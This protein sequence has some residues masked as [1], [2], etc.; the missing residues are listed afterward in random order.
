MVRCRSLMFAVMVVLGTIPTHGA[1]RYDDIAAIVVPEVFGGKPGLFIANK[2]SSGYIEKLG[3]VDLHCS[4]D[5]PGWAI[6][7]ANGR[8]V[9]INGTGKTWSRKGM[10][11]YLRNG[12]VEPVVPADQVPDVDQ[13]TSTETIAAARAPCEA[14]EPRG[15]SEI[16]EKLRESA[17][18]YA[19]SD[20]SYRYGR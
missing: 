14:R 2:R 6:I 9:A 5:G 1:D 3:A 7:R 13:A 19:A 12:S 10:K 16:L 11:A 17:A 4:E 15:V 8:L 20:G 18:R